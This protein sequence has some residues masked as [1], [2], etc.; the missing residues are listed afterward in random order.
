MLQTSITVNGRL[1]HDAEKLGRAIYQR[2]TH[3][4]G[5]PSRFVLKGVCSVILD[6]VRRCKELSGTEDEVG[7]AYAG[8]NV[9][10]R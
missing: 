6:M 5:A 8:K 7:G 9:K 2:L 4:N 1:S 10:I 3:W